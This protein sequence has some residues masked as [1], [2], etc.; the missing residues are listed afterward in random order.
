MR[1][2]GGFYYIFIPFTQRGTKTDWMEY[3]EPLLS[4]SAVTGNTV[5]IV[6]GLI[7]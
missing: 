1:I 7:E 6:I 5:V 2:D 3:K 4:N